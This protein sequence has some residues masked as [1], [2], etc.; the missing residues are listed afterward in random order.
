MYLH[1]E[2]GKRLFQA[3]V[4]RFASKG[5]QI[6]FDCYGSLAIRLQGFMK[7]VQNT[8]SKLY[9]GIDD[10]LVLETWHPSLKLVDALRAVDLPGISHLPLTARVQASFVSHMPYLR[11]AGRLLRYQF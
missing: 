5:G 10:P 9:W 2:E 8:G 3:L 4:S 6:M 7:P 1:E 11:N